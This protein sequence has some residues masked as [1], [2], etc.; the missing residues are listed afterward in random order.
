MIHWKRCNICNE[1]KEL[2]TKNYQF[3]K[4]RQAF[5]PTCRPC[6]NK[7]TRDYRKEKIKDDYEKF[8]WTIKETPEDMENVKL[9]LTQLGYDVTKNIPEQLERKYW[10]MFTK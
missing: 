1:I 7:R 5:I 8:H 10:N 3:R 2:N 9:L 6:L 4:D